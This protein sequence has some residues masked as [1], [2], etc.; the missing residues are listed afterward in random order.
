METSFMKLIRT[1]EKHW[2][3]TQVDPLRLIPRINQNESLSP[4]SGPGECVPHRQLDSHPDF[5]HV[6]LREP[7]MTH[8]GSKTSWMNPRK[9]TIRDNVWKGFTQIN[10]KEIDPKLGDS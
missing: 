4:G 7:E 3:A 2:P 10:S 1:I 5:P 6:V 9:Q 8:L